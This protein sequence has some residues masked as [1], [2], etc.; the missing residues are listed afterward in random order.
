MCFLLCL[1][2]SSLVFLHCNGYFS[3]KSTQF[4]WWQYT[5]T[6][7]HN[8]LLRIDRQ[9]DRPIGCKAGFNSSV[10]RD[11]PFRG[12]SCSLASPVSWCLFLMIQISRV[13]M[14]TGHNFST[15]SWDDRLLKLCIKSISTTVHSHTHHSPLR[16]C[17]GRFCCYSRLSSPLRDTLRSRRQLRPDGPAAWEDARL[18]WCLLSGHLRFKGHKINFKSPKILQSVNLP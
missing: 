16:S 12:C 17:C 1:L 15:S 10:C 13:G 5:N 4:T 3:S 7:S 14:K 18:Y 9:R 2:R 11:F 8:S 6:H